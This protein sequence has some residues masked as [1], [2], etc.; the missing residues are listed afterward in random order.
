M[1]AAVVY[2]LVEVL[3]QSGEGGAWGSVLA[4]AQFREAL[5]TTML[6]AICATAGCLVLGTYLAVVLAF[7]PVPGHRVVARVIDTVLALPSFVITLA[8]VLLYGV[9]GVFGSLTRGTL[10]SSTLGVVLAEITFFTPFVVRPLPRSPGSP[11]S[12]STSRPAS[13]PRR[14]PSPSGCCSPRPC[15]RS[16]QAAG[17]ACCSR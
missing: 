10:V 5:G 3:R 13:A 17:S 1:L 14:G 9:A 6:I 12:S 2:P 4:S 15:P 16:P 11:A 8:F 7:V